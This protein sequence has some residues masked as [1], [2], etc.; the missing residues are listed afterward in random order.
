MDVISTNNAL[1]VFDLCDLTFIYFELVEKFVF[2]M[3]SFLINGI[4]EH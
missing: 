2:E 1:L 3:L 4:I